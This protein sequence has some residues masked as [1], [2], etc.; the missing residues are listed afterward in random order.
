MIRLVQ[1]RGIELRFTAQTS[2]ATF[3]VGMTHVTISGGSNWRFRNSRGRAGLHATS[4]QTVIPDKLQ[5]FQCFWDEYLV[6]TAHP[7]A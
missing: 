1:S 3:G 7:R 4:Y 5:P 2:D 6:E